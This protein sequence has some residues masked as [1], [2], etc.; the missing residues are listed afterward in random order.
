VFLTYQAA[1]HLDQKEPEP[2]AAAATQ[3]LLLARRIGA[4]RCTSIVEALLPRFRPY[5]S[6]PGVPELL[7]LAAA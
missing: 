2:A 1:S 3:A 5:P 7:H 6:V 4:P